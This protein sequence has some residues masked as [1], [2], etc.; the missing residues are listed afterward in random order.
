MQIS[1]IQSL[2]LQSKKQPLFQR[3]HQVIEENG[4]KFVK[5]P[6]KQYDWDNFGWGL[7]AVFSIFEL[8]GALLSVKK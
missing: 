3:R 5:V 6:K 8:L 7:L 2:N 1:S 4:E